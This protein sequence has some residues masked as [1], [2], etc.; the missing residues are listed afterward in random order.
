MATYI[1]TELQGTNHYQNQ[2]ISIHKKCVIKPDCKIFCDAIEI[3][4]VNKKYTY[5]INT[6]ILILGYND[7]S[8]KDNV[9]ATCLITPYIRPERNVNVKDIE[10]I[11]LIDEQSENVDEVKFLFN[12]IPSLNYLRTPFKT[13]IRHNNSCK[14]VKVNE[15][16]DDF[17]IVPYNYYRINDF[18]LASTIL[19]QEHNYE[20]IENI[21]NRI[22]DSHKL[23]F[24]AQNYALFKKKDLQE[25]CEIYY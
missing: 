19:I 24:Y 12:K 9:S 10:Y 6:K 8:S 23:V 25:I 7:F 4:K 3:W 17:L 5:N 16:Y 1:N 20:I 21:H 13:F 11:Y 22:M 18:P 2:L 14:K 15:T